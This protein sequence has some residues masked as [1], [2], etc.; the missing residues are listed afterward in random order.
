MAIIRRIILLLLFV[1]AL[2][3]SKTNPLTAFAILGGILILYIIS[4]P[5]K[6]IGDDDSIRFG[7]TNYFQYDLVALFVFFFAMPIYRFYENVPIILVASILS[8]CGIILGL[9]AIWYET[10][11]IEI[12]PEGIIVKSFKG[13]NLYP[14]AEMSKI[15]FV[16]IKNKTA[17]SLLE[18]H[19]AFTFSSMITNS[20]NSTMFLQNANSRYL[21]MML[22]MKDG[23]T[24]QFAPYNIK[25]K[26]VL[27]NFDLL[28]KA[29]Y[30]AK[31]KFS[32]KIENKNID[33]FGIDFYTGSIVNIKQGIICALF[34]P[35]LI[36]SLDYLRPTIEGL[37]KYSKTPIVHK[38]QLEFAKM[39]RQFDSVLINAASYQIEGINSH[40]VP[41]ALWEKSFVLRSALD[42]KFFDNS[43]YLLFRDR[44][45]RY[46]DK[47]AKDQDFVL[48]KLDSLG[49]HIWTVRC[50]TDNDE[51]QGAIEF[52]NNNEI[53]V[54]GVSMNMASNKS[55]LFT[56]IINMQSGKLL[57]TNRIQS[58]ENITF[59]KLSD[60]YVVN[61][62]IYKFAINAQYS[63]NNIFTDKAALID[64]SIIISTSQNG[65]VAAKYFNPTKCIKFIDKNQYVAAG[66][67]NKDIAICKYNNNKKLWTAMIEGNNSE[68]CDNLFI[69]SEN[70]LLVMGY[71][72]SFSSKNALVAKVNSSGKV[73]WENT[74]IGADYRSFDIIEFASS[75]LLLGNLS[76]SV[77]EESGIRDF[78][79]VE[80]EKSGNEI[81]SRRYPISVLNSFAKAIVKL[82][83]NSFAILGH[84]V[85]TDDNTD[86]KINYPF[87]LKIK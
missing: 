68:Y 32:N 74:F 62:G 17:D 15:G 4:F 20:D 25:G 22:T 29:L 77:E 41:T 81:S 33:F 42:L 85:Y 11:R 59:S 12:T 55:D 47:R 40:K 28:L 31:I 60:L 44:N 5:I 30:D 65:A 8:G 7:F 63:E 66:N 58:A 87:L 24:L 48:I 21:G 84:K 14:F 34:F 50:G 54:A 49:N 70:S 78:R 43:Y 83:N 46:S 10:L 36:L 52:I 19:S 76:Q 38:S 72:N 57:S 71:S 27:N 86:K 75:Y 69:D 9:M 26:L 18:L 3:I 80:I 23:S 2:F 16:N 56:G 6:T 13:E 82:P 35:I 79:T 1:I 45:I 51:Y 53:L 64:T 73:L 67:I 61:E 37:S 39:T